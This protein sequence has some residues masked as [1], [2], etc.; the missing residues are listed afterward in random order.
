MFFESDV[1]A[2]RYLGCVTSGCRT[3]LGIQW[4]LKIPYCMPQNF[5][6]CGG[7]TAPA[8]VDYVLWK[9]NLKSVAAAQQD[10]LNIC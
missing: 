6:C 7:T 1:R 4:R 3:H 8:L 5:T 2:T 9:Q 10:A